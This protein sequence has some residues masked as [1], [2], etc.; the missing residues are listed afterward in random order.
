MP[1]P[2]QRGA[3]KDATGMA[4]IVM[5]SAVFSRARERGWDAL[6]QANTWFAA[7][8]AFVVVSLLTFGISAAIRS[9]LVHRPIDR[10]PNK[11]L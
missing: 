7:L 8:F 4:G 1:T 5:V 2:L 11:R 6:F 9:L 3:L 10:P